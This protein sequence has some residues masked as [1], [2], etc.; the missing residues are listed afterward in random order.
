MTADRTGAHP[1]RH[2]TDRIGRAVDGV[3]DDVAAA[4]GPIK[5]RLRGWIHTV[6]APVALLAGLA[7]VVAAPTVDQRIAAAVFTLCG[8]VLFGT[9]AVYHRGTWSER[10]ATVLRRADHSN[11]FLLIAGTYTPLSVA[12]LPPATARNLLLVVWGGALVGIL[13]RV[14]WLGAPRW[15]YV[16]LYVALGWTAVAV[17]P[18]MVAGG[19]ALVV[20]LVVAGGIVYTLGALV[21]ARKW[22][23]P[24]PTWFGFHEIFHVCT[25][26]GWLLHWL[27]ALLAVLA[28]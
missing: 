21:Y 20:G 24:S 3:I 14:L 5:P 15:L 19:G 1:A 22:P 13:M 25:V 4:I 28:H 18:A 27:A 12:L 11:I 17:L 26:V 6:T 9:S 23:D 2:G 10:V 7:L 8:L 16:A